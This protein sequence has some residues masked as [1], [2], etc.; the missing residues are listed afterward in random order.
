MSAEFGPNRYSVLESRKIWLPTFTAQVSNNEGELFA[1][2]LANELF[3]E[4]S[5]VD[6]GAF[7]AALVQERQLFRVHSQQV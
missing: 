3:V 6:V 4:S 2:R 1:R 5:L 7:W